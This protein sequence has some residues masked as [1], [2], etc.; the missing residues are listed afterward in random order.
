MSIAKNCTIIWLGN[1]S[2]GNN[3]RIDSFCKLIV[4][5]EHLTI[6]AFVHIAPSISL[7]ARGGIEIGDYVGLS[8]QVAVYSVNDD[9]S[10]EVMIGPCVDAA[11]SNPTIAPVRIGRHC[12]V[13]ASS[14]VFLG[15]NIG[16][17]RIKGA[18]TLVN[19]PLGS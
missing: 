8:H 11:P 16:E 17:G 9:Y 14:V 12:V 4:P 6:G 19:R 10:G 1:I 15:C 13:G 2:I 3:C 5:E 7:V 18:M